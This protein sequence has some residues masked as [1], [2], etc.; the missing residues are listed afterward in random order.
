MPFTAR[1]ERPPLFYLP[2]EG[3]LDDLLLRVAFSPVHPLACRGV[4]VT[5]ARAFQLSPPCLQGSRQTVLHWAF[6][7]FPYFPFK[8]SLVDPRLRASNEHDPIPNT[9]F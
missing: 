2:L 8:G 7:L 4:P 5:Q 6:S 3:G 1:I 9:S